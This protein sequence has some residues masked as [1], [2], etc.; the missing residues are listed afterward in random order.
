MW[1]MQLVSILETSLWTEYQVRH[2][3]DIDAMIEIMLLSNEKL[4]F[5]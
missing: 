4:D 3:G 1:H 2:Y 5:M